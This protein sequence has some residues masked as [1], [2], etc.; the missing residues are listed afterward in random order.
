MY[1]REKTVLNLYFIDNFR[2]SCMNVV[3]GNISRPI[4]LVITMGSEYRGT[5]NENI[6]VES[7]KLFPDVNNETFCEGIL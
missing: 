2:I 4:K 3:V 7:H 1:L 6:N 5:Y